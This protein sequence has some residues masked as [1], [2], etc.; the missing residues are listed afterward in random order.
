M[1]IVYNRFSRVFASTYRTS[2]K[3][4]H[5]SQRFFVHCKC[6]TLNGLDS[7]PDQATNYEYSLAQLAISYIRGNSL[8][9]SLSGYEPFPT[10]SVG[11]FLFEP[12]LPWHCGWLEARGGFNFCICQSVSCD[13]AGTEE[14]GVYVVVDSGCLPACHTQDTCLAVEE[15]AAVA[16]AHVSRYDEHVGSA[17]FW[18]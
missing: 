12:P 15:D 4:L 18:H 3:I 14:V 5:M 1:P 7:D 10:L 6:K 2:I 13:I 9:L 17:Q 11:L 8:S 16:A